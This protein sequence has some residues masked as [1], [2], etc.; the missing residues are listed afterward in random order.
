MRAAQGWDYLKVAA[1]LFLQGSVSDADDRPNQ[2]LKHSLS[3]RQDV[4]LRDHARNDIDR[5]AGCIQ[6]RTLCTGF[7]DKDVLFWAASRSGVGPRRCACCNPSDVRAKTAIT[8][9]VIG[10]EFHPN[11]LVRPNR[12]YVLGSDVTCPRRSGP[13]V[14]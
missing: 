10:C 3:S 14:M 1:L 7:N 4:Y 5:R 8:A 9:V 13:P 6:E 12:A 2:I 11:T